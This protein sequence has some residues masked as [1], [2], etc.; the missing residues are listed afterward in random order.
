MKDNSTYNVGI[1]IRLSREDDDSTNESESITN[2]RDF[3]EDYV[4]SNRFNLIDEYVDDGFTGTNF[5]R[6]AF[7][8]MISDIESC[9]INCVITKDMSR[10]GRDYIGIGNYI[11]KYFPEH[12]IRY[13]AVNDGLDTINGGMDDITPFKAIINDYYAK[14]ISKK[15]RTAITTMKKQGKFLGGIPPYGYKFKSDDNHYELVIDEETANVVR[16]MFNMYARGYSLYKIADILSS[17]KIP[18]PSVQ[19]G[20]NRGCKSTAYGAWQTRTIDEIL[21]NPTYIGNLTQGR[22]KKVN[23]KSKKVV[24]VSKENW[25]VY[26]NAHEPIIDKETFYKVQAIYEK[27]KNRISCKNNFLLQGFLYCKE[28]GHKIGINKTGSNNYYCSC[29]YYKKYSKLGLCTPHSMPYNVLESEILKEVRKE[30]KKSV[31]ADSLTSA[32][33]NNNKKEKIK[34]ELLKLIDKKEKDIEINENAVNDLYIAKLKKE[35]DNERYKA[36]YNRLNDEY[37]SLVD[38][39]KKLE[40]EYNCLTNDVST[41]TSINYTKIVK[42]YLELKKPSRELLANLIDKIVIDE[43]KNINIY[44]KIKKYKVC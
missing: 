36:L 14:D 19:K 42:E 33:K 2:Q 40:K 26:E 43:D 39:L 1:Y 11:E 18:I 29:N 16:R 5:E 23:Y 10:L 17:E 30:C 21:K 6:P 3:L 44:Y 41:N 13:I 7:K 27:N 25:I 22:R 31:K 8:R 34:A 20:L 12:N 9:R 32:L 38:E 15:V 4:R 35:I 24:R 28:C 37:N